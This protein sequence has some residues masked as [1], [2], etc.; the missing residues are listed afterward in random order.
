MLPLPLRETALPRPFAAAAARVRASVGP[1][2]TITSEFNITK[3]N[4]IYVSGS[5]LRFL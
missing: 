2:S 3:D 1:D 4:I 5:L